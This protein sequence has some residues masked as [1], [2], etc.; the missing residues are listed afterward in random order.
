MG[1]QQYTLEGEMRDLSN[2]VIKAEDTHKS[3]K[4]FQ[5][6]EKKCDEGNKGRHDQEVELMTDLKTRKQKEKDD[7]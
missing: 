6:E 2:D 4:I 7:L 1:K 5:E 3:H